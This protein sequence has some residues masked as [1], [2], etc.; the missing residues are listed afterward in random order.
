MNNHLIA[1]NLIDCLKREFDLPFTIDVLNGTGETAFRIHPA[2]DEESLFEADIRIRDNIRFNAT[3]RPQK[4]G[5][6]FVS[7]MEQADDDMKGVFTVIVNSLLEAGCKVNV[8]LNGSR[9][10]PLNIS[11][12]PSHWNRIEISVTKSPMNFIDES[13]EEINSFLSISLNVISLFLALVPIEKTDDGNRNLFEGEANVIRSRRYERNPVAR[14]I[15]IEKHGYRCAVCGFDFAKEYG[16]IGKGFIEVHHINPI[17]DVGHQYAVDPEKDL[18]P[19]CS[20]CHSM[21]HRKKPPYMPDE[22][23]DFRER[24][25]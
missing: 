25:H 11:S 12:W 6:A 13:E 7:T 22:L 17:S 4:Y 14:R 20:N 5:R 3:I 19:L 21:I 15:C 23:I 2:N 18:I 16:E 10:D 9:P 8:N 24:S 1:R